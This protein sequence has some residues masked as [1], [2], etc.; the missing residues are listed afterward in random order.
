[1]YSGLE[2]TVRDRG[3]GFR[4]Y[5]LSRSVDDASHDRDGD[6]REVSSALR[7]GGGHLRV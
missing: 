7:D 3:L 5:H 2:L 4:D 1:M 6:A